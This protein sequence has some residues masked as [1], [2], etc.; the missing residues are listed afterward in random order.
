MAVVPTAVKRPRTELVAAAQSQQLVAM[1]PPRSSSLQAPIMLMSGHEG[2]VYC[3]KFHPNGAT[4]ASSG[5]DRLILMWNVY[6]DCENYATLKGHSGA[7]MEL[8]YNTDGSMLFSASTDKTVGVWDSET[9]ERIKRLK[10]HT[11]FVNTCYPARRGPQLIC[12]G[13]DDGTV[14]LW[15]IRK[16]GAIHTFQNTYQVLAVTFNDT[17][18]QILS[19]GIDNDIKVW[20]LRQNKLIYNM[21]GHGD[22]VTGLSLSSEGSY[23]LSNSMD[24]TVERGLHDIAFHPLIPL[25]SLS[26]V[27]SNEEVHVSSYYCNSSPHNLLRCSWSTDGSKIAAGSAD[28]FVYIWDTTSRRIL[29]KLPG[30]AGSVN[31]VAF[32]PEEPIVRGE[33][34]GGDGGC[35]WGDGGVW[36][37]TLPFLENHGQ[38]GSLTVSGSARPSVQEEEEEEEE[39]EAAVAALGGSIQPGMVAALQ[40]QVFDFLGYQWAPILANFLHIMSVIL[41]MFG[42][43]QFRFRYL[44]FYA[45]WLVLW[46]GWNSFI[47]CFYLEV[48]NLSQD[49]DF[50]MTFNT[51]LHR[52]WWMEH[53]PGCLV[54]PVLDSRMAPDDHHVI[55]VSGCLLDYQYIEVLSSAIQILLAL[56]GFVYACYVS[57]VFQDDEDSFDFIGGFDSYGYQPPQKSSHLQLQ[58]L[59]TAG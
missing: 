49:R 46:V 40:R 36:T 22:S 54:T 33:A 7:V 16:K 26:A 30:H 23:L 59:Y 35:S 56:F 32:H 1:G 2:E 5:F 31:E 15:D 21:H 19:G 53:G 12:T 28:R 47:I 11:S 18:D 10:G 4:L 55:T 57:K 39:E 58:P 27:L 38:D 50:L 14:K 25:P 37:R 34:D 8:H 20:D 6:G 41:G 43:V 48:G 13:S 44:I 3:C 24:N 17:S 42:T 9:G 29:Y 45:V 51:S 52:S